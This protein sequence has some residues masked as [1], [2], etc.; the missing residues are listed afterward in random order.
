ME[1]TNQTSRQYYKEGIILFLLLLVIVLGARSC[2]QQQDLSTAN[3]II[4]ATNSTLVLSKTK[5]GL[6]VAK[7]L[8]LETASEKDFLQ[9]QSKN[10]EI[11]KL[12]SLVRNY[13]SK[14]NKGGSASIIGT[15]ANIDTKVPT[16]SIDTTNTEE[17]SFPTYYSEFNLDNWVIGTISA[18]KDSTGIKLKFKEELDVVI[19]RDKT[20]F[21]GLGKGK[22]FSEVTLHNPFNEVKVLKTYSVKEPPTKYWHIGIGVLYGIGNGFTPQFILGAGLMWTP[23]N[24]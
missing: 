23:I 24:F 11:N 2:S 10:L 5:E 21:L 18:G 20:G 16:I 12:Q 19:G 13:K 8:A 6:L 14:L 7:N 4:E 3:S 15:E 9:L 22:P 1:N 17:P